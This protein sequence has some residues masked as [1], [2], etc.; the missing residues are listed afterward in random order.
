[1]DYPVKIDFSFSEKFIKD[2]L[3][4]AGYNFITVR[5]LLNKYHGISYK[6]AKT[7]GLG[8][9]VLN[10]PLVYKTNKE[11]DEIVFR[12]YEYAK[13]LRAV[14]E[15]GEEKEE[16]IKED[17]ELPDESYEPLL[18]GVSFEVVLPDELVPQ[19]RKGKPEFPKN[20]LS[21]KYVWNEAY[22]SPY[23]DLNEVTLY[24]FLYKTVFRKLVRDTVYNKLN[25][26]KEDIDLKN[27]IRKLKQ[28]HKNR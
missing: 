9:S 12:S 15:F 1:M 5:V 25:I 26:F 27:Q 22:G 6:E 24:E 2:Y 28:I 23:E 16:E 18:G 7:I 10:S 17:T 19:K 13:L 21:L 20:V 4:L 11:L 3:S 8:F 14:S